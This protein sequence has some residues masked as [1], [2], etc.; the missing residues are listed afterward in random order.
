MISPN[1]SPKNNFRRLERKIERTYGKISGHKINHHP[2][3]HPCTLGFYKGMPWKLYHG[4]T[5]NNPYGRINNYWN[6]SPQEVSF[7]VPGKNSIQPPRLQ[8]L[9]LP[10]YGDRLRYEASS[11]TLR[12]FTID[13]SFYASFL[14]IRNT[15]TNTSNPAASYFASGHNNNVRIGN[16]GYFGDGVINWNANL[17]QTA[18]NAQGYIFT[19]NTW[20]K[21]HTSRIKSNR[22]TNIPGASAV[23][24]SNYLNLNRT[25]LQTYIQTE[26]LVAD[27][28]SSAA[29]QVDNYQETLSFSKYMFGH[30]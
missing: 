30:I 5:S 15:P 7:F 12:N 3:A 18:S 2:I 6:S 20:N 13:D 22:F 16:G 26:N 25:T 8:G 23:P 28:Y 9:G 11:S 27:F 4:H 14:P 1:L 10:G 21:T 17:P 19:R 29:W 24:W